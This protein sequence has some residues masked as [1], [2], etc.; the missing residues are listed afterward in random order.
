MKFGT[1]TIKNFMIIA[2]AEVNLADRGLVGVQGENVD[3]TSADSNGAGKSS[4]FEALQW[5]LYGETAQGFGGDE[6]VNR[7][8]DGGKNCEVSVPIQ[9]GSDNWIVTR[10][11]KHKVHKNAVHLFK[12]ETT[13]SGTVLKDCTQ[14]TNDLT[15]KMILKLLGCPLDVFCASIYAGQGKMPEL[16]GMTDKKLKMLVEEAAGTTVLESAYEEARQRLNDLKANRDMLARRIDNCIDLIST[17]NTEILD[18]KAR[19]TGWD[20]GNKARV[21]TLTDEAR[22]LVA[23][24]RGYEADIAA[25]DLPKVRG[26]MMQLD[27]MIAAVGGEQAQERALNVALSKAQGDYR[28]ACSTLKNMRDELDASNKRLTGIGHRIGCPCDDCG[29]PLTAAEIAPSKKVAEDRVRIAGKRV[30][31]AVLAAK[32]AEDTLRASQTA[33]DDHRASM[34]DIAGVSAERASLEKQERQAQTLTGQRAVLIS[35]AR[36]KA[37]E[38]KRAAADPNPI[39]GMVAKAKA[40]LENLKDELAKLDALLREQNTGVEVAESVVKVFSPAGVRAHILDTVTPFLND[41]TARYL[42]VLSDGNITATWATLVPNA[43]GELKE[44]FSIE[45]VNKFGGEKFGLTSGGEKRK[46]SIAAAL[47]LQDLVATR[48]TKPLD[49]FIADEIDTALDNAGVERLMIVLEEKAR[50][51]GSVFVISHSDLKD[52]IGQTMVVTKKGKMSTI[53]EFEA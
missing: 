37:D 13:V 15:Q 45:V 41:Q 8:S 33:L 12:D 27:A 40:K 9:D 34:T 50:E 6:I 39:S 44:K 4:A 11:R 35:N 32:Q 51:R 53:S 1:M 14:G 42:A 38:A 3:D 47:A 21:A 26:R 46:V 48:A 43:K 29:R 22:N 28:V 18:L 7:F 17:T 20:A 52:W 16:A 24:A 5:C 19:E 36:A 30:D 2:S 23:T 10:Y 49:L 25:I 31:D